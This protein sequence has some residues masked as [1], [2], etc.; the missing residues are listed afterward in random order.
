M[1][2]AEQVPGP[3]GTPSDPARLAHPDSLWVTVVK[4]FFRNKLAVGGLIV[5][6]L[7]YGIALFAPLLATHTYD[8][9]KTGDRYK[10]PSAQYYM[11]T[12]HLGRDVYSRVIYGSR[13]SLSVGFISAGVA[14]TIGTVMG[15][16]AGYYG[17]WVDT[18]ISRLIE[19]VVSMPQFFLLI[20]IVSV[21]ERSIFIIMLIIGLTAW[22]NVARIVRGQFLTLREQDFTQ[23]SRALGASD[24]RI[25]W[26]HILPNAMAPII[27]TTTLRIGQ[28]ILTESGLSFLGFGNPPPFPSWGSMIADGKDFLRMQPWI[29]LFPGAFIFVTVLAFNFMGDGLRDALDPKLKR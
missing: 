26:R 11:G 18:A 9:M 17:G 27:V 7:L 10:K 14:V 23:A 16:L 1:A 19:V 15:A 21:V 20:T 13:V 8:E 2:A 24:S 6:I 28:A 5:L 4:R 29:S 25:I 12:D 22:P 3:N